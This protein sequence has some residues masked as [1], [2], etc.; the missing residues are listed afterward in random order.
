MDLNFILLFFLLIVGKSDGQ[1]KSESEQTQTGNFW[2]LK[3]T[4]TKNDCD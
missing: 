4:I 2:N 1:N 3:K